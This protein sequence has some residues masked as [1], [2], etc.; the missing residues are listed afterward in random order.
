[1]RANAQDCAQSIGISYVL[2]CDEL[3][4]VPNRRILFESSTDACA[5]PPRFE[6]AGSAKKRMW[7]IWHIKYADT[8]KDKCAAS[9]RRQ[10]HSPALKNS[11]LSFAELQTSRL[12]LADPPGVFPGVFRGRYRVWFKVRSRPSRYLSTGFECGVAP[13]RWSCRGQVYRVRANRPRWQEVRLLP[14]PSF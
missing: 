8:H 2:R 4:L 11:C 7:T 10:Q 13:R 6:K 3:C 14:H 9:R 1:M 5:R 12:S